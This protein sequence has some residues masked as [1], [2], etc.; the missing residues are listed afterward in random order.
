MLKKVLLVLALATLLPSAVFAQNYK[1]DPAHSQIEFTVDHLMFFKVS[2]FFTDFVGT[3]EADPANKTLNAAEATIQ[4]TSIDTRIA[5][6]DTHL[7]SADFFDAAN[8]PELRFVSKKVEGSGH[9]IS[10]TGDLTIRGV[11]H[12]VVLTGA[13]L[14][15]QKD[16][17]GNQRAGFVAKGKINRKD[18]GLTW[19][20]ALET[21]GVMV[22]DDV[23]ITLQVQG[24]KS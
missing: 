4:T 23:E 22:G 3:I 5:K 15:E 8:H 10:V 20:K 7:R 14:G 19:N 13:F 17:W 24:I 9:S 21:G 2:G 18:Y 6:R 11:T 1:I 12:E 16:P